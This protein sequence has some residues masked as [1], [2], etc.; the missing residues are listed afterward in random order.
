VQTVIGLACIMPMLR[1][2]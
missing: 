2:T 1:L